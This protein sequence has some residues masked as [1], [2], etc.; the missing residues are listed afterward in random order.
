MTAMDKL[1]LDDP[2]WWPMQNAIELRKAQTGDHDFA[3]MDLEQAMA[4]GKLHSMRRSRH[5]GEREHLSPPFEK[6]FFVWFY[7][8]GIDEAEARREAANYPFDD[9]VFYVWKPDFDRLFGRRAAEQDDDSYS[10]A[11]PRARVRDRVKGVLSDLYGGSPPPTLTL[12]AIT[13]AVADEC[14]RRGWKRPSPDS[15]ARAL[16]RRRDRQ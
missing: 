15:V 3:V 8:C 6:Q 13:E 9:W 2:R 16:G 7:S 10:K 5:S 4:S 14:V 1:P 12:K 11:P